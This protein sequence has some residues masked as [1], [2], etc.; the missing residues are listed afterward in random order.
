MYFLNVQKSFFVGVLAAALCFS[1]YHGTI[2]AQQGDNIDGAIW[3]FELTK[4]GRSP[5]TV[6]GQFR[7]SK[8]VV[9]QKEKR[10]SP[11]FANQVGT[12][13]PDGARAR[14]EFEGLRVFDQDRKASKMNGVATIQRNRFG[15][16]TGTFTDGEGTNWDMKLSRVKE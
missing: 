11:S 2:L 8:H 15:E 6:K 7:V 14:T 5:S 16:W 1:A 13:K 3:Q 9:Y 4:K 12:N 10:N